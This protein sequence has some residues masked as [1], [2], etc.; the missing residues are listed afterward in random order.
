MKA[1][2]SKSQVLNLWGK[3]ERVEV[4][5]GEEPWFYT[6]KLKKAKPT[7]RGST[8]TIPIILEFKENRVAK[9]DRGIVD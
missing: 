6:L 1:G 4:E 8:S 9:K 7:G 5:D 3:P 2:A